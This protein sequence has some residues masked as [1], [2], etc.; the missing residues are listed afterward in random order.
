MAEANFKGLTNTIFTGKRYRVPTEV[1][2]SIYLN[3]DEL[4]ALYD[5]DLINNPRLDRVR[6]LFL[7]GCWTG[8]RF[9]DFTNITS[10]NIVERDS[11]KYI[12]IQMQKTSNSVAVPIL[13]VVD[14][15]MEKY[16]GKTQNN[17][18]PDDITNQRMNAYLKEIGELAA[19]D[20]T[21]KQRYPKAAF[22]E[23]IEQEYTKAG[24]RIIKRTAK[25][26]LIACHTA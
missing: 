24:M 8:L 11:G 26:K 20:V 10:R 9:S 2:D 4:N 7:V 15:I 1:V 17:L 18:P 6:D 5:L 22:N 14:A 25:H 16:H 3:E 13:P 19:A 12:D 21:I 23:E